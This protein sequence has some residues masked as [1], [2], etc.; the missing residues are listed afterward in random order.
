MKGLHEINRMRLAAGLPIDPK[1]EITES[2]VV[3]PDM[4][5]EAKAQPMTDFCLV[6]RALP[7]SELVD[8]YHCTNL[9]GLIN[10]IKG[11]SKEDLEALQVFHH[12]DHIAA[13]NLAKKLIRDAKKAHANMKQ[14]DDLIV[15]ESVCTD[16]EKLKREDP[17]AQA[18]W[19]L[20]SQ[21]DQLKSSQ[22]KLAQGQMNAAKSHL[23]KFN[24]KKA[25]IKCKNCK[26]EQTTESVE[27]ELN[28]FVIGSQFA[29]WDK[30]EKAATN[31]VAP[32][33]DD[34]SSDNNRAEDKDESP[35]QLESPGDLGQSATAAQSY[36]AEKKITVPV[37]IKSLLKTEIKQAE[38][39]AEKMNYNNREA[40]YFYKDLAAMF[41][42]LLNHLDGGTVHDIKQAQIFM[43]SL[44]GPMLHKIP[45]D[46]VNYLARGGESASLKSYMKKV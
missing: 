9:R 41:Q 23:D 44:M 4:I 19:K 14:M 12:D 28:E 20:K 29:S 15:K 6:G 33:N 25:D 37:K 40:A 43:T 35:S 21:A 46:V 42:D 39:E 31:A 8:V 10:I 26:K 36:D 2:K 3:E 22:P 32:N 13:E 30:D 16:C 17:D 34:V 1:L 45:A 24:A 5:V 27:A 18:A 38:A 7:I 11:S